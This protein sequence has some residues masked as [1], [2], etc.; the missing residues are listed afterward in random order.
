MVQITGGERGELGRKRFGRRGSEGRARQI[1]NARR[2]LADR[3]RDLANSVAD[4]GDEG[5][6][7]SVEILSALV[8]PQVAPFSPDDLGE[9]PGEL[10]VEDVTVRI[11]MRRG[12][13]AVPGGEDG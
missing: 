12:D 5:T 9:F 13:R 2:L 7:G 3:G 10:P 6:S 11:A 4:V 8:V 1:G